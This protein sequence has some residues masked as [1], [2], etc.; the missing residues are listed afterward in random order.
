MIFYS[1]DG[2]SPVVNNG[3]AANE[4]FSTIPRQSV[5]EHSMYSVISYQSCLLATKGNIVFRKICLCFLL[6]FNTKEN[7]E[8]TMYQHGL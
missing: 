4:T 8:V 6:E 5:S 2:S 7:T 3:L 1:M